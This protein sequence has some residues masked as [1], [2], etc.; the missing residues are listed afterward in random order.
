MPTEEQDFNF[1]PDHEALYKLS[2]YPEFKALKDV[3]EFKIKAARRKL[4]DRRTENLQ[5]MGFNRGHIWLVKYILRLF[6]EAPAELEK[7]KSKKKLIGGS[8]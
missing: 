4:D 3:F 8:K 2:Q 6:L 7:K 1:Q 5:D